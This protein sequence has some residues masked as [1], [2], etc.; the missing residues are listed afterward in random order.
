MKETKCFDE[1]N[2]EKDFLIME[3]KNKMKELNLE[4]ENFKIEVMKDSYAQ[5]KIKI[6]APDQ[7][8]YLFAKAKEIIKLFKNE[9]E[10]LG[11][12]AL[13]NEEKI[14]RTLKGIS[15]LPHNKDNF[16][17]SNENVKIAKKKGKIKIIFKNQEVEESNFLYNVSLFLEKWPLEQYGEVYVSVCFK[18][19]YT[20]RTDFKFNPKDKIIEIVSDIKAEDYMN[21]NNFLSYYRRGEE[22]SFGFPELVLSGK[23]FDVAYSEKENKKYIEVYEEF[24]KISIS[25]GTV[26]SECN[27]KNY[28][29]MRKFLTIVS[30]FNIILLGKTKNEI[31]AKDKNNPAEKLIVNYLN[32]RQKEKFRFEDIEDIKETIKYAKITP[33]VDR[34]HGYYWC[35]NE[36]GYYDYQK[37]DEKT[38]VQNYNK[39][40][41]LKEKISCVETEKAKRITENLP[42]VVFWS[43]NGDAFTAT[44]GNISIQAFENNTQLRKELNFSKM[45][46]KKNFLEI[47]TKILGPALL[48]ALINLSISEKINI[49]INTNDE[50]ICFDFSENILIFYPD[51]FSESGSFLIDDE[52]LKEYRKKGI[53]IA[54]YDKFR[55]L[56]DFS[57]RMW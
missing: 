47:Y 7:T 1:E 54:F 13:K 49:V 35:K 24:E 40:K 29:L 4:T 2:I 51:S 9:T 32:L 17:F 33:K 44:K 52:I 26:K 45:E 11:K 18:D 43:D 6:T 41:E 36:V 46:F 14:L 20:E 57:S 25:D 3:T 56:I 55:Y 31:V 28:K 42:R 23:D 19:L 8:E 21:G 5:N 22:G 50:K 38:V 37:F 53:A 48:E 27:K 15:L 10:S 16:S 30:N 12:D 34:F 39:L